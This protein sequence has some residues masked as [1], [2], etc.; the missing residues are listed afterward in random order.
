V[1]PGPIV[2][3][4]DGSTGP[5]RTY[6]DL[7]ASEHDARLL[8]HFATARLAIVDV[9]GE[10]SEPRPIDQVGPVGS[11]LSTSASPD[12]RWL[13]VSRLERPYSYLVPYY[14][15]ARAYEVWSIDGRE[16]RVVTRRPIADDVPIEGV[17][18]G[19]RQ[20]SWA[21]NEPATLVWAEAL[22]GGDPEVE[23]PQRDRW[24]ALEAPFT[25]ASDA[26]REGGELAERGRELARI[27]HRARGIEWLE[28]PG[29]FVTTEY[30]RDRRWTRALLHGAGDEPLAIEDRS[31]RD[32]YGDPGDLATRRTPEGARVVR[33]EDGALWRVG[34][35]A[36]PEGDRPFL[37]RQD[38]ATRAV[39]VV[40]RSE[41]GTYETVVDVVALAPA[42]CFVTRRESPADPPNYR[43]R[44]L[45]AETD[46]ALTA[47]PD[48]TPALRGIE[49]RL[50][51]YE[52]ADGV[53][54][55]ATLYLPADRVEGERLPLF[56]WA[57]PIEFND[58]GTAGQVSGSADRFTRVS[59]TSP[60]LFATR[61]WA[62]LD[63]ATMPVIGDP[64]TVNDTFVEQIVMAAEAA[65]DCAVDLGVADRARVAIG[66]HSYGAFMTV[67]LLAHSDLF[68]AGV[69]RSGAYNRT[70]TPFGFQSE[71]RTL[72]EAPEAYVAVSPFLHADRVNEPLLLVHGERDDNPGTFPLQ[73]DR[74]Y[75]AIAGNGGTVR[76]L[77][78]PG[79]AHGYR[80]RESVLHLAAETLD[81][82]DRHVKAAPLEAASDRHEPAS[83]DVEG[84]R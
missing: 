30:D 73:S 42:P 15:F 26:A 18:T 72:W 7:L 13:L 80:A 76:Y 70:L 1:P 29:F 25:G 78:L 37:A 69:A 12:G 4:T 3:A 11:Y 31:A 47:F 48:P 63:G 54:L 56:V 38:L 49:K 9:A 82:L 40:W 19:P 6:Q 23:V 32:R 84:T 43:L 74:L 65:I 71:R 60:L 75:H 22:D 62:V 20:L 57:Y 10:P 2:Q 58:A 33:V 8:D 27:E 24:M 79:E 41:P 77:K 45:G 35:G 51:S 39:D 16:R 55:S 59:G 46:V 21:Q 66:G 61:G 17:E 81:W 68:R 14:R 67:N 83:E 34:R 64:E 52:R 28:T 44:D 50:L 5:V 36:T 53:P